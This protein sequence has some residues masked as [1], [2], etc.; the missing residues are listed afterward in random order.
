MIYVVSA[1]IV[2]LVVALFL[3]QLVRGQ[4]APLANLEDLQGLTRPVD[5]EALA[6][7]V[8][9][10]DRQFLSQS[11]SSANFRIVQRQ[12]TLALMDYVRNIAHNAG[13]LVRLG[14]AARANPNPQLALA[15]QA[16]LE[17]ALH[18]RMIAMLVLVKLYA[19]SVVPALPFAGEDIFRDYRNLTE[20]VLLYTRLQRPAFAGRMGAML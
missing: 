1:L 16:M 2:L 7:L 9:P 8:D 6:N 12:R 13:L 11:L 20:T 5:M 19:R 18:V 17:R 14:Q 3:L 15:A 4:D 10:T